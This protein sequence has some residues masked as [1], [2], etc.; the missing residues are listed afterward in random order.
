MVKLPRIHSFSQFLKSF[1]VVVRLPV[2]WG[3]MDSFQ[4]VNNA[5]YFKYQETARL[6]FFRAITDEIKDPSFDS[7]AFH[8]GTGLGPILSET[9]VKFI[10]PLVFPDTILVGAT[11]HMVEN[12]SNRFKILHSVWSFSCNRVVAEGSGTVA[13]YNYAV[14]QSQDFDPLVICAIERLAEKNSC[15]LEESI[16]KTLEI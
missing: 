7:K 11:A 8:E 5:V 4:H 6:R 16:T 13:S 10:Y 3:E 2:Q 12:K 1:P 15:G 14:G 9:N